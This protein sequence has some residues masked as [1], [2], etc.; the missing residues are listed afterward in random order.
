MGSGSRAH[1]WRGRIASAPQARSIIRWAGWTGIAVFVGLG[2]VS[3]LVLYSQHR[4]PSVLQIGILVAFS[5]LAALLLARRSAAAAV[6]L[7]GLCA[8]ATLSQLAFRIVI[9]LL[10]GTYFGGSTGAFGEM[11]FPAVAL[12]HLAA[13][14]L[15]WRAV[16]ATRA[17]PGLSDP[18]VFD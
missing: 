15:M 11:G 8:L 2:L 13:T 1:F 5:A 14:L 3:A 18:G 10:R 7:F 16:L 12:V 9:P 4:T 6:I 17:L